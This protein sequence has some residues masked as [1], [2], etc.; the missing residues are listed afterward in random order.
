MVRHSVLILMAC[1]LCKYDMRP[2][3]RVLRGEI[4]VVYLEGE[5]FEVFIYRPKGISKEEEKEGGR[6]GEEK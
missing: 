4:V 2:L 1:F 5:S 3:T 6:E